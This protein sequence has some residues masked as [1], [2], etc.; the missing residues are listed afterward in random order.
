MTSLLR[1]VFTLQR[2]PHYSRTPPQWNLTTVEPPSPTPQ[3]NPHHSGIPNT[4]TVEPPPQWNPHP[5]IRTPQHTGCLS[6]CTLCD[7]LCNC[8]NQHTAL[9]RHFLLHIHVRW[10]PLHKHTCTYT[11]NFYGTF[12]LSAFSSSLCLWN[13]WL[14]SIPKVVNWGYK[15]LLVLTI[16]TCMFVHIYMYMYT[17]NTCTVAKCNKRAVYDTYTYMYMYNAYGKGG[18]GQ[19]SDSWTALFWACYI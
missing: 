2:N 16:C 17:Y 1:Y 7:Y 15:V 13:I 5:E 4:T 11:K 18:A 9:R 19:A 14:F 10:G 3:Q 6:T 8:R 12:L